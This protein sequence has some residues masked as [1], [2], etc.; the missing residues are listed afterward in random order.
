[1][2]RSAVSL[3]AWAGAAIVGPVLAQF[4]PSPQGVTVVRS[5]L[6][7]AISISYKEPGICETTP[8]VKSYSGYIHLPPGSTDGLGTPQ[9]YPINTFFWFFEARNDPENAPLSIWMNGGPGAS[10]MPG[11]LYENGPCFINPDSQTTRLNPNSWN[12]RVNMLYI[13]QPVQAGFSYDTL[14]NVTRDLFGSVRTLPPGAPIPEQNTTFQVGT[15]SS[16]NSSAT[17]RGSRNGAIALW[18]FAQVFFQ[19]FPGYYTNDGRVSIATQSYGGRYGPALAALF[20]E[21]NEKILNGTSA[22]LEGSK[23]IE[24][25]T[26]LLVNGCIDRKVQWPSYPEMAYNNTYGIQT[27]SEEWYESMKSGFSRAGGCRDQINNCQAIS[28]VYDPDALGINATVNRVC[29]QAETYCTANVRD[30]YLRF[31]GRDYYDVTQLE[32]TMF[33]DPFVPGYLNQRSVQEALGVPLN[34]T[35]SS[36]AIATA[37]RNIGD[38]NRP[39]WLEDMGYLL[40]QGKKVTLM[41]GDRDFACNWIGGEAASLAIPWKHQDD[42]AA[43]GYAP[44]QTNCTFEG[45]QVR[46]YGNLSFIR[47]YQAGHAVPAYQQQ[48]AARIFN[49][50]LFDRD[51]S[52]GRID[53]AATP[54][55]QTEGP[56]DVFDVKNEVPPQYPYY[57]YIL[58]LAS[59]T[60]VQVAALRAGTAV[61]E[62]YI[63]IDPPYDPSATKLHRRQLEQMDPDLRV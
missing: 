39:G 54:D 29:Q 42:F 18:H 35:G 17:S 6:N 16:G 32:P 26:L 2:V 45:G 43:A 36:N 23:V 7:P 41:Y 24:L 14:R 50:A 52:T 49:R 53:T 30:P 12:N 56:L 1:M 9:D 57:C 60:D 11:L 20:Q 31:S 47:V 22:G 55:Y 34:F 62:N 4:P 27:V 21:Q 19:E 8:G 51:V 63:M 3:L 15:Y 10:S 5:K 46:Q 40:D 25:D 28:A 44:L 48:S 38:Y 61:I 33:P 59:C 58:D 37:Y 13:D